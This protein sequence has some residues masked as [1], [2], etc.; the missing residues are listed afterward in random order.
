MAGIKKWKFINKNSLKIPFTMY[1][2]WGLAPLQLLCP[3]DA[4]ARANGFTGCELLSLFRSDELWGTSRK[5]I[6]FEDSLLTILMAC[7]RADLKI[8]LISLITNNAL[9]SCTPATLFLC[10]CSFNDHCS[11]LYHKV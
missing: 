9:Y 6:R 11:V 4:N 7:S 8:L 3:F 5:G 2:K 1:N 10:S